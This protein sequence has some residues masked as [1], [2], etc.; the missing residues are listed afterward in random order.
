MCSDEATDPA[1]AVRDLRTEKRTVLVPKAA[2]RRLKLAPPRAHQSE[3]LYVLSPDAEKRAVVL[4][5]LGI[6]P[7]FGKVGLLGLLH[8]RWS[9][10]GHYEMTGKAVRE[11]QR[12]GEQA[13]ANFS[14]AALAVM[15]DASQEPDYYAW[16]LP[17]AHAQSD[18]DDHGKPLSGPW[19]KQW[20]QWIAEQFTKAKHAAE[21]ERYDE[22]LFWLG[23]GLHAVQDL[24]AHRGQTYAEHSYDEQQG[25][26]PDEDPE[27]ARH[28]IRLS[29]IALQ[30]FASQLDSSLWEELIR[31][32]ESRS[33]ADDQK[34][35]LI[36]HKPTLSLDALW[37]Y[38]NFGARWSLQ[39]QL[40]QRTEPWCSPNLCA[41]LVRSLGLAAP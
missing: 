41:E 2:A 33:L 13:F 3:D 31:Y 16:G 6:E 39:P 1:A 20:A 15:Q 40:V 27:A 24:A 11:L 5:A 25:S 28:A 18:N 4:E 14:G 36:G 22:S 35:E 32:R 34:N 17:A 9:T 7:Y 8:F 12:R 10:D 30:A 21:S 37:R 23:Y 38:R 19:K 26:S 29:Q